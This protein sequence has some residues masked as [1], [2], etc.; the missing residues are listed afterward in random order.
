MSEGCSG[1]WSTIM[2][3]FLENGYLV[4]ETCAPYEFSHGKVPEC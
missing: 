3:F 1:G 4:S 2:G